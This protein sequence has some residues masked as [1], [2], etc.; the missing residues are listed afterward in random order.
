MR[1]W[2][3]RTD[4]KDRPAFL[5][6]ASQKHDVFFVVARLLTQHHQLCLSLDLRFLQLVDFGSEVC[7]S[8]ARNVQGG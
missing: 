6:L 3:N 7:F 2:R 8:R 5:N 4:K 1:T